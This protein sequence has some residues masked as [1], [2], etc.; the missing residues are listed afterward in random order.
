M[1]NKRLSAICRLGTEIHKGIERKFKVEERVKWLLKNCNDADKEYYSNFKLSGIV[2]DIYDE[3]E[4]EELE[5][6]TENID[7]AFEGL[8]E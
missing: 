2:G 1:D 6:T 5:P 8:W 4:E 7:S 3:L